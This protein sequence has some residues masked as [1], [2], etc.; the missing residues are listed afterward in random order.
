[1]AFLETTLV[2]VHRV[3]LQAPVTAPPKRGGFQ[4]ANKYVHQE[5]HHAMQCSLA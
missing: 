2:P 4:K 1:M 5:I 3:K